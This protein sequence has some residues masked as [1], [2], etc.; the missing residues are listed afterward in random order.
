MTTTECG[1]PS[2]VVFSYLVAVHVEVEDGLVVGV[3]VLDETPV[4]NP[5]VVEGDPAYLTEAVAAANDGQDWPSW[6]F[7]Y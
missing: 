6:S 4:R 3:T 5:T 7:G 2:R 1:E